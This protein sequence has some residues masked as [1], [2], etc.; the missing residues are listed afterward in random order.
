[1]LQHGEAQMVPCAEIA[2]ELVPFVSQ[3]FDQNGRQVLE[4]NPPASQFLAIAV[5][6]QIWMT[7]VSRA[8]LFH[9]FMKRQMLEGVQCIVMNENANRPL[10]RQQMSR[11]LDGVY[12]SLQ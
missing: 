2:E 5:L 9:G 4:Q 12:Q 10:R 1:M 11:V 8:A 6:R 7:A 3:F